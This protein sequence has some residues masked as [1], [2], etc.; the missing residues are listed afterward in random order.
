MA[1]SDTDNELLL[2]I[3]ASVVAVIALEEIQENSLYTWLRGT[4]IERRSL[5]SEL[6]LS[7]ARPAADG[8]PLMW[9]NHPLQV[10]QLGQLSLSILSR[11]INE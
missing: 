5:A 3:N 4:V 2:A 10:S 6:S 7:C 9:V 1:D 8:P 11:S